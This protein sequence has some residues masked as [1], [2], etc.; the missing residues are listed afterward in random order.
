MLYLIVNELIVIIRR[1]S[2]FRVGN[3]VLIFLLLPTFLYPQDKYFLSIHQEQSEHYGQFSKKDVIFF[4]SLNGFSG[5]TKNMPADTCSLEK[6]VFGFHPYW[7]GSTYLN[8]QWNLLSDLCYFSYEVDP[9]TGEPITIHNW[10]DDP[11]IDSAQANGVRTHLC[12]TLFSG[13]YAFF[14]ST[15]A[16]QT[17]IDN[18]LSL[19]QQRNADGINIDFEAVPNSLGEE[20]TAFMISLSDQFHAAHPGGLVSIDLPAVDWGNVFDIDALNDVLDL[21]FVMGYDY[22]WNGSGTAGP[23]SPLY[24]MTNSYDY[25]LCRTVSEYQHAGVP[26]DKLILG[27]PYY[28]RNW[29]TLTNTV[30]SGTIG[31]GTALTYANVMNNSAGNFIPVNYL[32]E[33]NS[34]SSCYIYFQNAEWNQCFIGLAKDLE[35]RYDLINYRGLAGAGIWALGYDNGFPYLWDALRSRFTTCRQQVLADTIYDCG[36][37]AWNYYNQEE[38]TFT[39]DPGLDGQAFLDFLEFNT[40]S[41]YDSLHIFS[42]ADS[43]LALLGAY[44]GSSGPSSFV[45]DNGIFSLK[46]RSDGLTTAS[47]WKAVWHDGS[48]GIKGEA[49]S[50]PDISAVPNPFRD[51]VT[52]KIT[53]RQCDELELVCTDAA[54]REIPVVATSWNSVR[55]DEC[56]VTVS[57]PE[58]AG[59]GLYFLGIYSDAGMLGRIALISLD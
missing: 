7:M 8:Y 42:G 38:Y 9:N 52:V 3:P 10:L 22:Y 11:S 32:W 41:G 29:K 54:G 21:F 19:V 37:P 27:L 43:G 12:A 1:V 55:P 56:R 57:F 35:K 36:G 14:E 24:S 44:S 40:E 53:G 26:N 20:V 33:D 49:H 6:L 16:Q 30:P 45:S 59:P 18:L 51:D 39:I 4:D 5:I 13:H 58:G 2:T 34:F 23:V 31:Y 47:G 17:L 15:E 28:G 50:F 46:F 25:N 48:L